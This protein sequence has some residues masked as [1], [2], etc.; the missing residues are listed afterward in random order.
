MKVEVLDELEL[1]EQRRLTLQRA[2]D[3]LAAVAENHDRLANPFGLQRA[4]NPNEQ[5][6]AGDL[7][8]GLR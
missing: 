4:Q 5:R 3:V 8:Q 7:L 2:T 6:H 1:Q